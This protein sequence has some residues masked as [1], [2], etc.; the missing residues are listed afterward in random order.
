L[1]IPD[2]IPADLSVQLE[3]LCAR[4]GRLS[5]LMTQKLLRSMDSVRL[6]DEDSVLDRLNRA[7]KRG[8]IDSAAEWREIR[9]L[10]NQIAYE[11]VIGD[12]REL[13]EALIRLTPVL[14]RTVEQLMPDCPPRTGDTE[15]EVEPDRH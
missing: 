10:R 14:L 3:A 15:P 8:T 4:F 5:D 1:P 11:Y 13:F 7:E 9:E 6:E 12:L 2:P